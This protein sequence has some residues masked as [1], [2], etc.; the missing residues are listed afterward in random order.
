V[1]CSP[2][3]ELRVELTGNGVE[4]GAGLRKADGAGFLTLDPSNNMP[5][6]ANQKPALG[7]KGFI[8]T[9]RVVS[10]IPKGGTTTTWTYPSPQMF[11]NALVRKDKAEDVT[12]QDMESVVSVHNG[13]RPPAL[14]ETP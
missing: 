5:V 10:N 12:P 7:Q 3:R 9:Q 8:S 2:A 14:Y 6:E 11:Y 4:G 13:T 1:L